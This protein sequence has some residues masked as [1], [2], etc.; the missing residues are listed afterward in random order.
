MA[1]QHNRLAISTSDGQTL[2]PLIK[3]DS[4]DISAGYSNAQVVD[5]GRRSRW[6]L[7]PNTDY[8]IKEGTGS[9]TPFIISAGDG[10]TTFNQGYIRSAS[11][12]EDSNPGIVVFE[13]PNFAGNSKEYFDTSDVTGSTP[14]H[15]WV[16]ASAII[17][18]GG[19][20][21]LY[22]KMGKFPGTYKPGQY[23][24]LGS[25]GDKVVKVELVRL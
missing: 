21:A 7:Y 23:P 24:S 6:I 25:A 20:W 9:Y 4:G 15:Y 1:Y 19:E 17:V 16:G 18:T 5:D 14:G 13:H 22:G 11:V 3:H 10:V 12:Y 8:G 2:T